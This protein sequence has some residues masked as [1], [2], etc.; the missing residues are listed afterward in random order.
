MLERYAHNPIISPDPDNRLYCKKVYNCTIAKHEGEYFMFVRGVGDDWIS[1]IFLAKSRD[2]LSFKINP[3][4]VIAPEHDW[5]RCGCEDPRITYL[6]GKY[7]LTYTAYDGT[8][9]RSAMASSRNLYDWEKHNLMF[10]KLEHPQRENLP[11]DWSKSAAIFPEKINGQYFLLFGDDHIWSATTNDILDWHF[12][13][14][15]V[16]SAREGF[17]DAA[18]VEM[19]PSPIKTEKGWLVLYHGIDQFSDN[20]TYCLGA[21]L[22]SIDNPLKVIWRCSKPLLEPRE[23]YETSGLSDLVQG[24]YST[25][26]KLSD[27]DIAQMSQK[28][29]LPKSVFCCGVIAEDGLLK[30]YYAAADTRICMAT[31]DLESVFQS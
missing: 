10:P 21:A 12:N 15:P 9:A 20:R 11:T 8:T 30:I 28:N 6:S 29:T 26:R 4:P 31:I 7:W 24:G 3:K 22:L 16:I 1:R 23:S 2:G 14:M 13:P 17:F 27:S 18:F 5:E 19:G 25:L